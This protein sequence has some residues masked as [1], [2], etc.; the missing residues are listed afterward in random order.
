VIG[1]LFVGGQPRGDICIGGVQRWNTAQDQFSTDA[2]GN[3]TVTHTFMPNWGLVCSFPVQ[4]DGTNGTLTLNNHPATYLVTDR[5]A[6][7]AGN[8]FIV[9][10]PYLTIAQL[11]ALMLQ[12]VPA[13]ANYAFLNAQLVQQGQ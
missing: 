6:A 12:P 7:L 3:V 5:G 8:P 4:Q 10:T 1:Q 9:L 11:Q 13:G 2:N